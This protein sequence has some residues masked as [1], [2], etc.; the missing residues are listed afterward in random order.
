MMLFELFGFDTEKERRSRILPFASKTLFLLINLIIYAIIVA[1]KLE[2]FTLFTLLT[3]LGA[4][5]VVLFVIDLYQGR[6]ERRRIIK[7]IQILN[8]SQR[9]NGWFDEKVRA[10]HRL[11]EK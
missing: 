4:L 8:N 5:L 3:P 10:Y 11:R 6:E 9:D 1:A 7:S 2:I